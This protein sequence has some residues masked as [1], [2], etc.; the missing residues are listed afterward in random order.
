VQHST[1]RR[2][3]LALIL[4]AALVQAG[5]LYFLYRYTELA[6]PPT[7]TT[8]LLALYTV[9]LAIPVTVHLLAA[10]L[11]H[12][13]AGWLIVAIM[14]VMFYY[15]GWDYSQS[16]AFSARGMSSIMM[17]LPVLW[18]LLMP[19]VQIRLKLGK[20]SADY[21]LLFAY[22]W[23]NI[24][25]LFEAAVF[26]GLFWGL[27]ALWQA[28]FGMLHIEFFKQLF[29]EP[30]F[31]LPVTTL[32]FGSAIY[33]TGSAE[34]AGRVVTVMLNQVLNLFKWLGTLT[35]LLLTLFTLALLP[36]LPALFTS[37]NKAI[38]AVW[39]LWLV[40]VVVLFLNAAYRDGK[41]EKPY[42]NWIAL[43]MR[44]VIPLMVIISATAIWALCVR[45]HEYGLTVDRI[46]ALVVAGAA[47]LYS[48]G[49]AIAAVRKG[50]W[51]GGI[52]R[53]NVIVALALMIVLA[54]M[55]TPVLSPYRLAANS[56][57]QR[58]LAGPFDESW[59]NSGRTPFSALRYDT[60]RYGEQRLEELAQLQDHPDAERIRN[61][62]TSE[63]VQQNPEQSAEKIAEAITKIPI[64]PQGRTL[65][66]EL[67]KV[68]TADIKSGQLWW[69]SDK[70][71]TEGKSAM[72]VFANL[73]TENPNEEYFVLLASG[74]YAAEGS[75]Y[76]KKTDGWIRI[77]RANLPYQSDAAS[78]NKDFAE[79]LRAKL[80]SGD[81][82]VKEQ[83]W[84]DLWIG[85][86]RIR[87]QP[88]NTH[89]R[90]R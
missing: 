65:D 18:F 2:A 57:Y 49:Y 78:D 56:Q 22:S 58:I 71:V 70:Q 41:V 64:Y 12:S 23:H 79:D 39:L 47:V 54:L 88:D 27:L 28:L 80:A 51:F 13:R 72:G 37:G 5:I 63:S 32:I 87:I 10:Q 30:L 68:I 43:F 25:V 21:K 20:W 90:N 42:P 48:I 52:A 11:L 44:V 77:G 67:M 73:N 1:S 36:Q 60:G 74:T 19:F 24:I 17:A 15:F 81:F 6:E 59:I 7:A 50:A 76:W 35:A 84:K 75:V 40:A 66:A 62:A 83:E 61:L 86:Y 26:T 31:Y 46:W 33:L 53:V 38:S 14:A 89:G 55:L 69:L 82:S 8:W 34:N 4:I 45:V 29:S 3:E 85:S 16:R 9:A